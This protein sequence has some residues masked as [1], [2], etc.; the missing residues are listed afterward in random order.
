MKRNNNINNSISIKYIEDVLI[1]IFSILSIS[2]L[3]YLFEESKYSIV[4]SFMD[5]TQHRIAIDF[6]NLVIATYLYTFFNFCIKEKREKN[7]WSAITIKLIVQSV[8]YITI[9]NVMK[10][11][12]LYVKYLVLAIVICVS[13]ILEIIA[14]KFFRTSSKLDDALKYANV[15]GFIFFVIFVLFS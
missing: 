6:K 13:K 5:A 4:V 15:F 12:P 8:L 7:L 9:L 14:L 1:E 3:L 10:Y 2:C 11:E